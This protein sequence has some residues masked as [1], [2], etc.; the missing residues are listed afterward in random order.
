LRPGDSATPVLQLAQCVHLRK[1][2]I[3]RD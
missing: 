1:A 2:H 3:F